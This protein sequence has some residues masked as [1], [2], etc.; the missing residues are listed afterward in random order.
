M[1]ERREHSRIPVT[2]KVRFKEGNHEEVFFTDDLS[3][4][5]IFIRA[6]KPPFVGTKVDLQISLPNIDELV[7]VKGEVVW[8]LEGNGCGIRFLKI[9]QAQRKNI[10]EFIHRENML[11]TQK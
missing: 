2:T 6:E 10:R 11:I 7:E 9:T 4:G 8:R 3:E 5:G 1:D